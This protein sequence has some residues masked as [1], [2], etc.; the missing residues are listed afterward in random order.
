MAQGIFTLRQVVQ[1]IRQGAWSI[2]NAPQFVEYLCV[3]GGASG[4][5]G[6]CGAGGGAGW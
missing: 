4:G 3:A 5:R 6:G 1:A 2:Y